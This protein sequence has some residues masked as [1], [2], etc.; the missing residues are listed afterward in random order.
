MSDADAPIA[1]AATGSRS[2]RRL[3]QLEIH[4]ADGRR[5]HWHD[6]LAWPL[7]IGRALDNDIVLADPYVAAQHAIVAPGED[8]QLRLR[9][10]ASINGAVIEA[11]HRLQHV[12]G[13]EQV[14]LPT[15]ARWRLGRTTLR[16]HRAE[17]AL[18]EELPLPMLAGPAAAWVTPL[19]LL[20]AL[21]WQVASLWIANT[22]DA[23]FIDYLAPLFGMASGLLVWVLAWGLLSKLFGGRFIV[24]V[25]LWLALAV[26][27]AGAAADVVLPALAF[28]FDQPWLSRLRPLLTV[29]FGAL[30]VALHLSV[31]APRQASWLRATVAAVTVLGLAFQMATQWQR[32]DRLFGELYADVLLPPALRLAPARPVSALVEDLRSLEQP[33]RER[34]RKAKE[35]EFEP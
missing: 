17:D 2:A 11:G 20:L 5:V 19:L 13:G 21:V 9:V 34:A 18:A 31:V 3:A 8:G 29:G 33:L 1:V 23:K 12:A 4:D 7:T 26:M 35:D 16:V 22:A 30:L 25:H 28:A 14:A 6:V 10:L 24:R 32:S 15:Q 27:L